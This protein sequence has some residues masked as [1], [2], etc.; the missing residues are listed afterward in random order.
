MAD[1]RPCRRCGSPIVLPRHKLCSACRGVRRVHVAKAQPKRTTTQRGYGAA[2]Q[3]LRKRWD[4]E[5]Q[6]GG[7]ACGHC[8]LLIE[9]GTVWHL[10]HPADRKDL[11][12]VP[13]HRLCNLRYAAG[14]TQMRRKVKAAPQPQPKPRT[15]WWPKDEPHWGGGV[16]RSDFTD[17]DRGYTE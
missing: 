8:H 11:A 1:P 5:V 2:H 10:G 4:R 14:V 6:L 15:P 12:P 17:F 13:W 16:K 7:V 9:P 3:A